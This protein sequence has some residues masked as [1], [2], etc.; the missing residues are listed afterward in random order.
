MRERQLLVG[1]LIVL[2]A[3]SGFG[4]L[5]PLARFAY[6]RGL[7]P[8]SFV[9]W[10]AAFGTLIVGA[11]ALWW[12]RRG[13]PAVHPWHLSHRDRAALAVA[14]LAGLVLNVAMFFAF[15]RT[16]VALV[17]LGFY[18]YPALV[19][20][21]AT[22]RGHESLDGVRLAAL[23]LSLG[24]M[25]LVVA[26]G[27]S[28]AADSAGL[29]FDAIG[30]GLAL[31]AALSQTVFVTVSRTGYRAMP[32]EQATS[33][34]LGLTAIICALLA[35]GA[36]GSLSLG[37][38]LRTGDAL[39]L[40][41]IAGILAAGIPSLLFLTG[42]RTIGG[43]RTGILMLFEPVVG[44]FLAAALLDEQILPIQAVGGLAI[45]LAAVLVQ[46]SGAPLTP[47]PRPGPTLATGVER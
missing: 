12:I 22:V 23:G 46:R 34:I 2:G 42:I 28:S 10:R 20:V 13:R 39:G 31:L 21:V 15:E 30:I 16:T 25:V 4:L 29:R 47:T 38:P 27:L 8:L 43:T 11:Y 9:A 45:L 1:S 44:V 37:A 6:D 24:G 5:G 18:T 26:G 35:V 36:G 17:L 3:A 14:V 33:W 40:A 41:A 32:N 7:E 19:A